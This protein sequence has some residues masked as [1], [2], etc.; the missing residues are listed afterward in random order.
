MDEAT[1]L[2]LRCPCGERLMAGD[3]DTLVAAAYQHLAAF[4]PHL[5]GEYSREQILFM[6]Y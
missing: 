2:R 4:H 6:A 3:A 5:A 1:V